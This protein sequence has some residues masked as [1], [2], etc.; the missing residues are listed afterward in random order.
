[1]MINGFVG[2]INRESLTKT[3]SPSF[4][5]NL[6]ATWFQAQGSSVPKNNIPNL[7]GPSFSGAENNPQMRFITI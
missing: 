1:M 7:Q 3:I 5:D 2:E 4:T 6:Q